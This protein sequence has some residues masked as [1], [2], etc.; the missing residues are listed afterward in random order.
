VLVT[1]GVRSRTRIPGRRR[2]AG[3]TVHESLVEGRSGFRRG[4]CAGRRCRRS[5]LRWPGRRDPR[6]LTGH[7][8]P[9]REGGS[10]VLRRSGSSVGGPPAPTVPERRAATGPRTANV[11]ERPAATGPLTGD[12]RKVTTGF[13]TPARSLHGLATRLCPPPGARSESERPSLPAKAPPPECAEGSWPY[14][15]SLPRSA[16]HSRPARESLPKSATGL[17]PHRGRLPKWEAGLCGA[18]SPPAIPDA[19]HGPA[20]GARPNR[21]AAL[22]P[23]KSPLPF[24]ADD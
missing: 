17:R 4:H 8:G 21:A 16:T 3:T 12:F 19:G 23:D 9:A 11:P 1:N 20:Q 10:L 13:C 22:A 18:P 24:V 14:R 6:P 5:C 15:W 2:Y 7:T